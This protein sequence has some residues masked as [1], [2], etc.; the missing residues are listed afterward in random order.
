MCTTY[1]L[2]FVQINEETG[3]RR[4]IMLAF[5]S[6]EEMSENGNKEE[7]KEPS[8]ETAHSGMDREEDLIAI[9]VQPSHIKACIQIHIYY[10]LRKKILLI[11]V[12]VNAVYI[13]L[14]QSVKWKQKVHQRQITE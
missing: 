8:I 2:Y 7:S 9:Y 12:N 14:F 11:P 13:L 1:A 5:P 3:N 4:P 6:P 10:F